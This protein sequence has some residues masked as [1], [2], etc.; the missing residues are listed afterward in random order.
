MKKT[1]MALMMLIGV[2]SFAGTVGAPIERLA[3]PE[4]QGDHLVCVWDETANDWYSSF[5]SYDHSGSLSIQL[6]EAG[7]WYWVGVWDELG[8]E[9]VYGKWIGHFVTH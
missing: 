7:K 4:L 3:L 6:P 9:Y 5:T 1:V 2:C 8:E